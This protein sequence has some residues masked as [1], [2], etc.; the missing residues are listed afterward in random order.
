MSSNRTFY[1]FL[2]N[3]INVLKNTVSGLEYLY[4]S[5]LI[6][7]RKEGKH[8]LYWD[9]K[10]YLAKLISRI[11]SF[12]TQK[13]DFIDIVGPDVVRPISKKPRIIH[14]IVWLGGIGGAPRLI[15][16]LANGLKDKYHME[17]ITLSND[18]YYRYSNFK[19]QHFYK[20]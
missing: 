13:I 12:Y 3:I 10:K 9:K 14:M 18:F 4:E 1:S 2:L 6:P 19:V 11:K 5:S 17:G 20:Q 8:H 15:L 16:D 7:K